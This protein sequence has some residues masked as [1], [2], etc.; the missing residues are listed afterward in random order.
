M[1]NKT[2]NYNL[3]K[4]LGTENYNVED[5]NGNM[6]IIDGQLKANAD[7]AAAKIPNSL[8]TAVDQVPVSSGVGSWAVKTLAQFKTW[9]GLGSAA[10]AAIVNNLTTTAAG[11]V[12]D[13]SQGKALNDLIS[14]K[15]AKS[16]V[17]TKTISAAS[18]TGSAAPFS[19]SLTVTGVTATSNQELLPAID[20]TEAQLK[21]LQAANIQDGG[22]LANTVTLKAWG[23]KPL[24]DLPVRV[25]LRGDM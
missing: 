12:L 6:D 8:A 2:T 24:I 23:E 19:Y 21:A 25:I 5:Q 9:L 16:S 4:P 20:V 3:T 7:A 1:P 22:Q 17:V 11:S 13:A 18:W 10:Y 14:T 15:A